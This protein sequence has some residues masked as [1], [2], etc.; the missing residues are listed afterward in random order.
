MIG[1]LAIAISGSIGAVGRWAFAEFLPVPSGDFPFAITTVNVVGSLALGI[2]VGADLG[3]GVPFD[4]SAV[5]A[6]ILGGFTT[7]STWMV[8]IDRATSKSS[9]LLVAVV[10]LVL[11]LVAAGIGIYV[12]GLIG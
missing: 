2:F 3:A 4:T 11:G 7:F 12:G 9:A 8:D 10:P 1:V 5:T 6:G